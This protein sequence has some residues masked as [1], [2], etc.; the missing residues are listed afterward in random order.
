MENSENKPAQAGGYGY[1]EH[2][3][4]E[5]AFVFGLNAGNVRLIKFAHTLTGGKDGAD[6]EALDI[7]FTVDGA[8][9]NYRKFPITKAFAKDEQGNQ[10][11]V[12][13]PQHPNFVQEQQ[14]LSSVLV[15]IV[16]C[17]VE[18]ADIQA[19]L[20]RPIQSFAEY[21]KILTGL[22]PANKAEIA[23]D[24]FGQ[25][26]W[27]IGGE[28]K[29]TYLEFPKNMKHGRWLGAAIAP[30]DKWEKQVKQGASTGE[31]ALR[32]VDADGNV[33]P[34]SRNGWFMESHFAT[35]QK[36]AQSAGASAMQASAG[37]GSADW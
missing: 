30:K 29:V 11:E 2:V 26:Q 8:E 27:Q 12:T 14:N 35:Q 3:A 23:L 15:H 20:Q 17:F 24:A 9:K 5:S 31:V 28:N 21:C 25:Y 4:K 37:G 6:M 18:K 34:F 32:W 16:G 33:H 10:I 36:E 7:A 19:A 1:S 13:D 22:L